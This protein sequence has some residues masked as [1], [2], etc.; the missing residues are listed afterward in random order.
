MQRRRVLESELVFELPERR[1][2]RRERRA[3]ECD[4]LLGPQ[5]A[6]EGPARVLLQ[7]RCR[8]RIDKRTV[9]LE[10]AGNESRERIPCQEVRPDSIPY[11]TALRDGN[12][13]PREIIGPGGR[14]ELIRGHSNPL[15]A[16]E[17]RNEA[18]N[19][20]LTR[21]WLAAEYTCRTDDSLSGCEHGLLD[22]ELDAAIDI[23]RRRCG[24]LVVAAGASVENVVRREK[25]EPRTR[26]ESALEADERRRNVQ[27]P[28]LVGVRFA[29]L[30]VRRRC[31]KE[32]N[33][34]R[35]RG[36][37]LSH[38]KGIRRIELSKT[39]LRPAVVSPDSGV[40]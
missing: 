33:L 39:R 16:S 26:Q 8:E 40:C 2:R 24:D 27:G 3:K 25:H 21:W 6:A 13:G 36:D 22:L 17:R 34:R 12:R 29:P 37:E 11:P 4:E 23:E 5:S 10:R 30:D 20:I 14:G 35:D 1:S 32:D 7:R 19:K 28:C 9:Q 38:S 31:R 18:E 15:A